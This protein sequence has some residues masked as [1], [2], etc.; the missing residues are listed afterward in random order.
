[1]SDELLRKVNEIAAKYGLWAEFFPE[2][3]SVGVQGDNR[4]YLP[5]VVLKGPFPGWDVIE[6]VS[7][8]IPNMLPVN[9]VT[10]DTT[11]GSGFKSTIGGV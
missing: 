9:R 5:V 7:T 8:E 1:M 3:L 2:V 4:T 11:P 10:Y 6:R